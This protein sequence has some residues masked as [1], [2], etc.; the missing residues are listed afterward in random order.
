MSV[1]ID[2][3]IFVALSNNRDV[4]HDRA[5]KLM[6]E[7]SEGNFGKPYLS[8]Y[9]FDETI[10][11]AFVRS[12]N[13]KK[14]VMLGDLI[15]ESEIEMIRIDEQSFQKA[16]EIFKKKR[17][18]FTDCTSLSLLELHGIKNIMTFDKE[19]KKAAGGKIID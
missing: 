16:W 18:S 10:T 8:D 11:T 2:T 9:I 17:L 12:K 6:E 3:C 1:L 15:L 7:C 19:L 5:K 14:S 4:N 13:H